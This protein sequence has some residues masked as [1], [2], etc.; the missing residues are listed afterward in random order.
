MFVQTTNRFRQT[1]GTEDCITLKICDSIYH[2]HRDKLDP[3]RTT[4]TNVFVHAMNQN[5]E[6]VFHFLLTVPYIHCNPNVSS[7]DARSVED[8]PLQFAIMANKVKFIEIL[9]RHL[10]QKMAE[11]QEQP[12]DAINPDAPIAADLNV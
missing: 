3:N 12:L 10:Q 6:N 8:I 7:V 1:T 2:D 5:N 11:Q 9:L 4:N